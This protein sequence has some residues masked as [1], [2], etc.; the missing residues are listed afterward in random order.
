MAAAVALPLVRQ[1]KIE[2]ADAMTRPDKK[3]SERRTL[4]A[5]LAALG[6]R[7]DQEPEAGEAPER[8]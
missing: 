6:L 1:T 7:P 8:R 5:V 4:D 3:L 2:Y